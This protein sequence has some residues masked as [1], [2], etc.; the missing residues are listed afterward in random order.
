MPTARERRASNAF[1]RVCASLFIYKWACCLSV[2]MLCW[3]EWL[4][5]CVSVRC[6][7]IALRLNVF[8]LF[9]WFLR[10]SVPVKQSASAVSQY[11]HKLQSYDYSLY[12]MDNTQ[13]ILTLIHIYKK[14]RL[15]NAH[16]TTS[17][18]ETQIQTRSTKHRQLYVYIW[19]MWIVKCSQRTHTHLCM[20][21]ASRQMQQ[22]A[23]Q[24]N[25]L[26]DIRPRYAS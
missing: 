24:E 19:D 11:S 25:R 26:T 3:A 20:N 4:I 23:A 15:F 2:S 22:R 10:P 18:P 21:I 8:A 1:C 16:Q 13:Y 7:C 9:S 5:E 12:T 14:N 6:R 17:R